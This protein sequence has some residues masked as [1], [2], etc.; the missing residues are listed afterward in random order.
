[1]EFYPYIPPSIDGYPLSESDLPVYSTTRPAPPLHK[2]VEEW[3]LFRKEGRAWTNSPP[4][5]A[6]CGL[7]TGT[8]GGWS[9][10]RHD[11]A[12]PV[13]PATAPAGPNHKTTRRP[14]A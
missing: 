8:A 1:M 7:L 12:V 4:V 2:T 9:I 6:M 11:S 14:R 3:G 10:P 5:D 13:I